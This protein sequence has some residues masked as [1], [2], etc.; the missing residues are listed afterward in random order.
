MIA[1]VALLTVQATDP[2]ATFDA[3]FADFAKKRDAIQVLEARFTQKSI[4]PEE[5]VNSAGSIVYVK[6]RRILF[7]YERPDPGTTYMIDGEKAYEYESDI[8]QLQIYDLQDDPQT[9]VFFLGFQDNTE[10][11]RKAYDVTVFQS[12]G[13]P[14]D[15]KGLIIRPKES[16]RD[17]QNFR[18]VKLYLRDADYLPY[19][20]HITHENDS[21]VDIAITD[22]AINGKLDPRKARISLPGGTKII[23]NDELV[24]T[25]GA[26][27]KCVPEKDLVLVEPLAQPANK[28]TP[29]P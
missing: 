19:R 10:A 13:K 7:R 3:F 28:E 17:A 11:L 21:E 2:S 12:A 8:R 14:A 1:L 6:P 20:I 4:S 18:E 26:A 5:T 25:V 15:S 23:E 29:A 24:E 22:F 16:P 27:G 9:E